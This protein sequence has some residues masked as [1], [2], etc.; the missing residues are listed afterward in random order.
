M[1]T[2]T[3]TPEQTPLGFGPYLNGFYDASLQLQLQIYRR[4][5]ALFDA[6]ER[7]R[8]SLA[9]AADVHAWQAHLR[10]SAYTAIGGLPPSDSP[11]QPEVRAEIRLPGFR[12][13]KLI[14][15]SLPG[16]YVTANLY[17]PDRLA[18]P[19]GAVLFVCCHSEDA[20]GYPTYQGVCQR[21]ARNGLVVLAMDPPGQ[22]ERKSYLGAS[23]EE[24]VRWGTGEHTYAGYQCWWL[25]QSIARYFVH[26]ARR[27]LD[28]LVSRPEVDA[29]RLGVTG[30]SGGG[31]QT[32]WL[33][34]LEPR[35]AAAAPGTF[36]TSRRDYLWT[37]QA[38]DAEQVVPGG[39]AFGLDHEDYLIA[40][41]PRP[42]LVV[43]VDYDFFNVEGT[44]R[45]VDRARRAFD[46]LGQREMLRH[47]RTRSTHEYHPDLARA[48][49]EFFVESLLGGDGR[50]VDHAQ[51]KPLDPRE[52][53]CTESGQVLLDRPEDRRVFDLNLA[54]YQAAVARRG[55]EP[56]STQ[57]RE[58]LAERVHRWRQPTNL[59]PRWLPGPEV[60]G[61]DV[62][63]A[64]WWSERDVL[65][66]GVLLVPKG[67]EYWS[68][69]VAVLDQGTAS[70]DA[71]PWRS[72]LLDLVAAG[73]AVLVLDVRG[74]G[75]LRPHPIN[76]RGLVDDYGTLYKLATD[77]MWLDDSLPAARTYD[78][79]RA[80]ALAREEPEI[81]LGD[82][83]IRILGGGSLAL[84]AYL[85]A[86]LDEGVAGL[87]LSDPLPDVEGI[88][89]ER[90]Y[91]SDPGCSWLI[92]GFAERFSLEDLRPL[93][94]GR[95][96]REGT[97]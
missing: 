20:K 48:A 70:L 55:D 73:E 53:W 39:T 68:L 5:E 93:F 89:T 17:V 60:P 33:M 87:E 41:A 10:T 88:L 19:T 38:Q 71:E 40:F 16:V 21:L 95:E 76:P 92:P 75:A 4:S 8:D 36:V 80:L 54:E 96:L 24:L 30:N 59:F 72:R 56:R 9:T 64:F 58:W 2:G 78:I 31:T 26:D 79:L 27:A 3:P 11:L 94:A 83:P 52:L 29:A 63:Y 46:V 28:Y 50:E 81:G 7:H 74:V 45:T 34:L 90:L 77:L 25:G 43:S 18:G 32:S 82:R 91:T 49:A 47:V 6:W 22:G 65:G 37:G 57:A 42:T 67:A 1:T 66:A 15:Q 51:P 69:V 23:G 61:V 85:A 14:Y 12:I 97:G 44:V 84:C 35:L 86:A 13:E 62:H